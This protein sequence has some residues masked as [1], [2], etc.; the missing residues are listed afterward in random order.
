MENETLD[1][2][3]NSVWQRWTRGKADR[4]SPLHTPTVATVDANGLPQQRVMVLRAVDRATATLRFHTDH[5]S[6]KVTQIGCGAPISVV[7][8]DPTAKIQ[9]RLM[10]TAQIEQDGPT[11]DAAWSAAPPSSRRVYFVDPGPGTAMP[12]PRSGLPAEFEH[13]VPS[14]EASETARGSFSIVIVTV[15]HIDWLNLAATGH[16]RAQYERNGPDWHG[17]WV[18]P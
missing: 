16:R 10:G 6:A 15:S 18:I 3:F 4:R 1:D 11:A 8:Y 12:S 13:I 2:I 5:R 7:G 14:L 9:I 17:Q